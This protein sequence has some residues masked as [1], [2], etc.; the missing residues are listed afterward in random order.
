MVAGPGVPIRADFGLLRAVLFHLGAG[1]GLLLDGKDRCA[2]RVVL[3]RR[4]AIL[5][6]PRAP[7]TDARLDPEYRQLSSI[8]MDFLLSD[9]SVAGARGPCRLGLGGFSTGSLGGW[10][11]FVNHVGLEA[12]DQTV[13]CRWRLK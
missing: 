4:A 3:R 5:W 7:G 10:R 11:L 8:P 6:P 9:R 2:V 1:P 13:H 12:G